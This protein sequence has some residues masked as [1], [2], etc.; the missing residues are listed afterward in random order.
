MFLGGCQLIS[1]L[2]DIE[3]RRS[4]EGEGGAGGKLSSSS[5]GIPASSGSG[6]GGAGGGPLC[7]APCI[8]EWLQAGADVQQI[9]LGAPY[10]YW[11]QGPAGARELMRASGAGGQPEHLAGPKP[12]ERFDVDTSG[13]YLAWIESGPNAGVYAAPMSALDKPVL[14]S[15]IVSGAEIYQDVAL[16]VSYTYW[17]KSENGVGS[18]WRGVNT[19]W[20]PESVDPMTGALFGNG[21]FI[22]AATQTV[23]WMDPKGVRVSPDLVGPVGTISGTENVPQSNAFGLTANSARIFWTEGDVNGL[24][25]SVP[26][27]GTS[28]GGIEVLASRVYPRHILSTDLRLYWFEQASTDCAASVLYTVA[29]PLSAGPVPEAVTNVSSCP[30]NLIQDATF[31]YWAAGPKIYRMLKP[32]Q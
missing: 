18:V 11:L 30:T 13:L 24:I 17:F 9:A 27:G 20:T 29:L 8:G 12:I 15:G 3:L 16:T 23:F 25:Q 28:Q 6:A 31:I 14:V 7:P 2:S 21:F 26:I 32:T 19:I 4:S 22:S 5:T 10:I 1:G